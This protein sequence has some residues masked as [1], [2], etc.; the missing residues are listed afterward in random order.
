MAARL[1]TI[2][3]ADDDDDDREM[4]RDAFMES[5]IANPLVF[6][7]DGVELLDYLRAAAA[8]E[9]ADVALPAL[10]L[11]DLNMPRVDGPQALMQIRADPKLRHL[12]V[13]VLTTSKSDQDVLKCYQGGAN[14]FITKPVS[15]QGLVDVVRALDRYWFNIVALPD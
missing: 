1:L 10:V 11:L 5:R 4:T 6:V 12:P 2:I 3:V 7:N 13:V 14:S 15:F 9:D 8:A